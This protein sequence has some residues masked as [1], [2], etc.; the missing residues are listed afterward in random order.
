MLAC[1]YRRDG[2]RRRK[3]CLHLL[4][5]VVILGALFA[6]SAPELRTTR[7]SPPA[8]SD[9][10]APP[11]FTVALLVTGLDGPT[12]MIAGPDGR[13]WVAQLN[14]GENEGKGQVLTVN[15]E[16][17]DRRVLLEGLFKPTGIAVHAGQLWIAAGRDLLRA[18]LE[19]DASVGPPESV[20]TDLPFNGRSNGTLTVTPHGEILYAT[21]G[22][23]LGG[24][25][26]PGSATLWALTPQQPSHP[27]ALATGLK[28]AYGHAID[29]QGRIW[30]T[31]IGDDPID[32]GLPPDE[33]NLVVVGADFGWPQC[34]GDR[35]PVLRYGGTVERCAATRSPVA[36]F[37][38]GA[39]PTSVAVAPWD[40]T[41]LLVALWKRG[42]VV[43][44]KVTP[45]GDNARG[46]V[47]PFLSGLRN[48]QHLLVWRDG[49]LLVGD[50]AD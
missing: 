37:P 38:P 33:L 9:P 14:G 27:R 4:P 40:E 39:T 29:S 18:L 26:A 36:L 17:G 15:P 35:E 8:V 21:T 16:T 46:E 6:C 45:A 1:R 43:Q 44:V 48:P 49:S 31:E 32:D 13:L 42:E 3:S 11:G 30:T 25:A 50:F 28:G 22:A 34:A 10:T 19:A 2:A 41:V 5:A 24:A 23:R 20:F 47:A 7:L 12:Q